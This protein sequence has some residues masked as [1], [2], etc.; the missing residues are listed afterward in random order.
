M[1]TRTINV[2]ELQAKISGILRDVQKNTVYEVVRYSK[3]VAVVLSYSDYV[4]LRGEC[5]RCIEDIRKVMF[6]IKE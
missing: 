5:K 3:P 1:T 4:K 2:N 6:K